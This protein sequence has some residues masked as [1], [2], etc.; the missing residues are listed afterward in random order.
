MV[1]SL[2]SMAKRIAKLEAK[3]KI[4]EDK[5][6]DCDCKREAVIYSPTPISIPPINAPVDVGN[7][8]GDN[9]NGSVVTDLVTVNNIIEE[10]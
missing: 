10:V 8:G 9:G 3:V 5:K 2:G 7:S 1:I 4:L 6:C